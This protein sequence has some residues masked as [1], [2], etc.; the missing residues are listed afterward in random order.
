MLK[1]PVDI[2]AKGYENTECERKK[3]VAIACI[4]KKSFIPGNVCWIAGWGLT[5]LDSRYGSEDLM[6]NGVNLFSEDSSKK[7]MN[8]TCMEHVYLYRTFL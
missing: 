5:I 6:Q 8:R 4:P 3:C 7:Y 2:I 1:T